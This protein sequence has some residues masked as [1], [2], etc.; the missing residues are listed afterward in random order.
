MVNLSNIKLEKRNNE[1]LF[2]KSELNIETLSFEVRHI[3]PKS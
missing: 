1:I 2:S 3:L